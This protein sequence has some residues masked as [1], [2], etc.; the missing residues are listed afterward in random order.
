MTRKCSAAGLLAIA[1]G[2]VLLLAT[3]P[4]TPRTA[5]A[6]GVAAITVGGAQ[7]CA[8]TTTG[9]VR[10]WGGNSF[11]E[12]GDGQACGPFACFLPTTVTGLSDAAAIAA[13]ENHTCAVTS[14][15][16]VK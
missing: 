6:S 11:G 8:L 2:F 15:G 3:F 4:P 14:G 12:L 1:G 13:G 7:Q 5:S 16:G 10:C 9:F